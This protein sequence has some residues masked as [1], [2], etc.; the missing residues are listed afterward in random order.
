MIQWHRT[1]F[2]CFLAALVVGFA[3]VMRGFWA[4]GALALVTAL[5]LRPFHRRLETAFRSHRYVAA[6]LSVVLTGAFLMLPLAAVLTTIVVEIIR[7]SHDVIE[8]LQ[9]GQLAQSIDGLNAWI[10]DAISPAREW[11]GPDWNLRGVLLRIAQELGQA[12]YMYSPKF[13]LSTAGVGFHTGLWIIFLFVLFADGPALYRYVMEILPFSPR[14]EEQISREVRDMV[15]AVYVGMVATAAVNG[16][17]M[18][19][20]FAVCGIERPWMWGL[21]TFGVSFIPIV[22]ALSIWLGAALYL[23]LTGAWP[24]ALGLSIFGIIIIAQV[25]NIVKPIAMRGRVKIHPV[26]LLLSI[27]GGVQAMG[28]VGL[29]LGPV[30]VAIF[31]ASLRIYRREFV[32]SQ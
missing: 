20:A 15:I 5:V 8:L 21:V 18:C 30:L 7:F 3:Y 6:L 22:G 29:V 26:L 11:L 32:L 16:L 14:H 28:I 2:L 27:L 13:V 17:L 23:M 1:L 12:L 10:F 4:A 24:Y 9:Q 31:L 19:I 25:D